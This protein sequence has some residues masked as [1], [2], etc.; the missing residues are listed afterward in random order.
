VRSQAFV[1]PN[2]SWW[3]GPFYGI[4]MKVYD[5]LAGRLGLAPSRHLSKKETIAHIPTVEQHKLQGGV[6]YHDGQ[7]DDARLALNLAQTA[8]DHGASLLNYARCTGLLK[9]NGSVEGV[10][11]HDLES[12]VQ[13]EV[14]AK[15]VIN[16]TGVFADELRRIDDP[17]ASDLIAVSQ[18][19]HLVLPKRFLPGEAAIMVPKT[20][21][22]RVL[23]AVPWHGRVVVGP[24][25]TP[26]SEAS[27]EPRALGEE[28]EFVM[29]H[30]REYL[31]EDPTEAD[32]LSIFAGLRPLVK[33]GDASNTAALSCD[34]TVLV[35]P[36]GL[37]T[38]TG[39]KWT[40]YRKMAEDVVDHAETVGG[41]S[42]RQC[43]TEDLPIHGATDASAG[44]PTDFPLYGSD[45]EAI[46]KIIQGRPDLAE[47]LH[48][49]LPYRKAEVL[50]H[51]REEMARTVED[52][53]ARRTRALLL[54]ARASIEA[55]P[56]VA[57]LLAGELGRDD[58]WQQ[59]QAK[60]YRKLAEGYLFTRDVT[61]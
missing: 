49:E 9:A 35:S 24:T 3:E 58:I 30:A 20:A 18:G 32:V 19:I 42:H 29:T 13:F 31:A 28:R 7:F 55:A 45:A 48:P 36:S 56:V 2:Y 50:W 1:I 38:L 27:L 12:D 22:G 17:G 43:P 54:D 53:L 6:I 57:E 23:F 51:A 46:Q 41:L 59:E 39:G 14:K 5:Q 60:A 37:I 47:P 15:C 44:P 52:V 34:H 21:D 61:P 16:A 40:T 33:S 25:D 10:Q 8:T 11:I 4:G 26:L